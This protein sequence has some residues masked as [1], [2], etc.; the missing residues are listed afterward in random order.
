[1]LYINTISLKQDTIYSE[2]KTVVQLCE[3]LNITPC[4]D[5]IEPKLPYMGW[6]QNKL[7]VF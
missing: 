2:Q 1:M 7:S 5:S 4:K 6:E 3:R